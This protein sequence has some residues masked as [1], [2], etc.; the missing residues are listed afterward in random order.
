MDHPT[1]VR[2]EYWN[3]LTQNWEAGHSGINLMNPAK[4]IGKLAEQGFVA[5]AVDKETGEIVYTDGG[6]LL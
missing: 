5:R 6:D 2:I 3:L 1:F 4:Y